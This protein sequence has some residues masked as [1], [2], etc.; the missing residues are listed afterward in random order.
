MRICPR[1]VFFKFCR[2]SKGA[3]KGNAGEVA[4]LCKLG[5]FSLPNVVENKAEMHFNS[6]T[7]E[8]GQALSTMKNSCL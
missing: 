6:Q 2:L 5:N 4:T 8:R 7:T 1:T 3:K